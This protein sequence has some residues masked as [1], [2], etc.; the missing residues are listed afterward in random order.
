M[1]RRERIK[2]L[3]LREK[4]VVEKRGLCKLFAAMHNA[5][6]YA[7]DLAALILRANPTR[8]RIDRGTAVA[9][10]SIQLLINN[11]CSMGIF[12]RQM[13]RSADAFD[14]AA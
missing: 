6:P 12:D 3:H 14:L 5:M 8:K 7:D 10:R 9:H 11:L 2:F 4:L 13:R 1:Q